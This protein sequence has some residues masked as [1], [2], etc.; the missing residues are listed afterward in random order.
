MR[1]FIELVHELQAICKV[2]GDIK[3]SLNTNSAY[4]KMIFINLD[5][6]QMQLENELQELLG[7]EIGD[8]DTLYKYIKI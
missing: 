5:N 2:R 3:K 4:S 1:T 6:Y 7:L 8:W